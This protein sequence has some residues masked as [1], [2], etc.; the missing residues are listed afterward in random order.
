MKSNLSPCK[1]FGLSGVRQH[2]LDE[3]GLFCCKSKNLDGGGGRRRRNSQGVQTGGMG[4]EA[5]DR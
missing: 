4:G 3:K 5:R 1:I 2:L